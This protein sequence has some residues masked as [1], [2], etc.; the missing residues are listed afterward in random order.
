MSVWPYSTRRWE[1]LRL[2]KLQQSPLCEICL[3]VFCEVV[4]AEVVDHRTPIS[5]RGRKERRMSEAF[6]HLDQLA[7]LCAMHHNRKTRAEQ[8]GDNDWMRRGCDI[9]GRP[10]DRDHPWNE[11][12]VAK[13][14]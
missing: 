4:A 8:L 7:S 14:K 10:N 9:F 6:P 2:Q 5:E 1:R 12:S 13:I 11:P 3:Q